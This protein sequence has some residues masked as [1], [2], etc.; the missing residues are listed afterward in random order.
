[1]QLAIQH[2]DS[3]FQRGDE[4]FGAVLVT[5]QNEV[6]AADGNREHTTSDTTAH[7][8]VNAIRRATQARGH[9][10]LSDCVL[11]GTSAPCSM[12][13]SAAIQ[14]GIRTIVYGVDAGDYASSSLTTEEVASRS[15][16][17]V[18]I[19]AGVCESECRKQL[20]RASE[21]LV[22]KST[23]TNEG[24]EL[25]RV[26]LP[27][28]DGLWSV[29]V[30][31][32]VIQ[33]I[34]RTDEQGGISSGQVHGYRRIDC[35]G[36]VLIAS[37]VEPH[38]HLE[39]AYLEGSSA[40]PVNT[41][42]DAIRATRRLKEHFTEDGMFKRGKSVLQRLVN[43]GTGFA[44]AHVEVDPILGLRAMDVVERLKHDFAELI[45]LQ[46][47]VFPQE[48]IFQSPGTEQLLRRA[49]SR[50]VSAMGGVPY[51]DRNAYEHLE[52][53][54]SLAKEFNVAVDLHVDFSDDP[55]KRD[56]ETVVDFTRRFHMHGNVNVGHLT[57]LASIPS[58][59]AKS[60]ASAMADQGISAIALPVTDL[61]LG[62][63]ND[64]ISPRRGITPVRELLAS[65]VNVCCGGNNVRN[66][67]TPFGRGDP[68]LTGHLL[69]VGCHMGSA[70]D[71][72][73]VLE[74][75]TTRAAAAVGVSEYGIHVG[76]MANLVLL[77]T[78]E[79]NL[80]LS[81]IPD[82]VLIMRNGKVIKCTIEDI[83]SLYLSKKGDL[84]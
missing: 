44:R 13:T 65:G 68:I 29:F 8:E 69:A 48:G 30:S 39:K 74:M 52:K 42:D 1:M 54:F 28:S 4:P 84:R 15:K 45:D 46:I 71:Q 76:H 80:I 17:H 20:A 81:E 21:S 5:A 6:V 49:L 36:R 66:A 16:S 23:N 82:R 22:A 53:V 47:V 10:D 2:A 37:L 31:G 11:L 33:S 72:S 67:F 59:E 61:Y 77:D 32:G 73:A 40:S 14:A 43:W 26:R 50:S 18:H 19:I 56:I 38:I 51:N 55:Q 64:V 63:R 60:I 41:I 24:T 9:C 7:A 27:G 58:V 79:E 83:S 78:R 75:I 12:C 57:S 34:D 62:G 35:E 25:T 3:A 70:G